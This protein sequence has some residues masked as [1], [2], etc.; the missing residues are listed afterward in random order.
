[1]ALLHDDFYSI[2]REAA[3]ALVAIGPPAMGP[4]ISALGDPDSDVR[5]RAA[6]VLAGIGDARA[7]EPLRSI[8]RDEDWYVRKAAE[9]AVE[10]IRGRIGESV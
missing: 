7:V 10:K 8:E 5:K 4:V 9:E 1:M 3:A 2:R 6:D